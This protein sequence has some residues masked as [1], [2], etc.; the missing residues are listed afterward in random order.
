MGIIRNLCHLVDSPAV[1]YL[2]AVGI[3]VKIIRKV[4][5]PLHIVRSHVQGTVLGITGDR[6]IGLVLGIP[7]IVRLAVI[8]D[9]DTDHIRRSGIEQYILFRAHIETVRKEIAYGIDRKIDRP[10]I[11][12][13]L[14]IDT[15]ILQDDRYILRTVEFE[16][17]L[18]IRGL[19]GIRILLRI[20]CC[21][22]PLQAEFFTAFPRLADTFSEGRPD[23]DH[24]QQ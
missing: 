11:Q 7:D 6:V 20:Q 1:V 3:R 18:Q 16:I 24:D 12:F 8:P 9:I 4:C 15:V 21:Q 23:H 19:R 17:F 14:G 13:A 5:I 10:V 22:H 2:H